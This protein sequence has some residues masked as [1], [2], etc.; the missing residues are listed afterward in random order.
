MAIRENILTSA[1][2]RDKYIKG[3]KLL[4]NEFPGPTTT[5]LGIAGPTQEISTYDLFVVWHHT[6]MTTFTPPTQGD[7]NAAHRGPVFL[8]WHRFMLLQLEMNLQRVLGND[9][10]FGLPYWDW[11]R[12]GELSTSRQRSAPIWAANCMGGTGAPVT[13]GPFAFDPADPASWRVRIA[14]TANGQLA[15]VNR[16]LRRRLGAPVQGLPGPNRLPRKS[17]TAFATAQSVYDAAPWSTASAGFRNLVE[18]WQTQPQI[19]APSLHN[20]VHVFIGGDMSPS[21]SPNDPVFYLN[22]CNVDRIWES[23]MRSPPAGHGRVYVPAQ[24]A[25][26]SL[27]G[28]RLNDR[29]NSLLSG[30][31]TPAQMLDVTGSYTYDSLDV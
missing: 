25:P 3:V 8:P 20:R 29:L 1:T 9:L 30:S 19:P 15:Q 26:A 21:T 13:T 10:S 18:G 17:H 6:A 7:R 5:S 22:H 14:A 11:A 23:W 12:D 24:N 4:K 31:T 2:A 16:G 28:H 27:R